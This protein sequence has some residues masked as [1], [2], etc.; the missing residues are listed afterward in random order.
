MLCFG[1]PDDDALDRALGQVAVTHR[2]IRRARLPVGAL[3]RAA[4]TGSPLSVARFASHT[5]AAAVAE[6]RAALPRS[7]TY[8]F[9]GQMALYAP[10]GSLLDLVD[11]DSAKFAAYAQAA[12]GPL[13]A[14]YARED[15]RLAAFERRAAKRAAA[16]LFVSE[17][18]AALWSARGGGGT[19]RVLPNGV[20]LEHFHADRAYPQPSGFD[21]RPVLL[22][23]GQMDYPP[24]VEAVTRFARDVMPL[25]ADTDARFVIAGRA[26]T[27]AVRA[28]AGPQV[29]VTG[30]V[31]DMRDWLSR[32]D[33]AV[34]PLATA[35]GVQNKVLEAL[36]MARATLAST[37]AA[38]GL[39]LRADTDLVI[40]DKSVDQA[41]VLRGLLAD[42]VRR[43][44]L[45]RAGR[46]RVAERYG[47][48]AQL[49]RLDDL[50]SLAKAA[51]T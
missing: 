16:V 12:S 6:R 13:R 11:V 15:R 2:V 50:L 24:N 7:L 20:D 21:G 1:D 49:S 40:A 33:V 38:A 48:P 30:E 3:A 31:G 39:D 18:E 8:A 34:A 37:P 32:A 23:T 45:G 44:R 19:V 42:P 27:P 41:A 9:S 47:W 43:E 51:G 17:A 4:L 28:L 5:M 14:V 10:T 29:L 25:L 46:R 36:A 26:P 22:F 35:R